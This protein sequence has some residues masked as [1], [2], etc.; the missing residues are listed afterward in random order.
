MKSLIYLIFLYVLCLYFVLHT[1]LQVVME[2]MG[3]P[4][5]MELTIMAME[6][7]AATTTFTTMDHP[8]AIREVIILKV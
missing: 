5:G 4:E 8:R 7:M 2:A 1:S 3:D 6:C